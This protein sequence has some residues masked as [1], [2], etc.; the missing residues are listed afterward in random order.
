[1]MQNAGLR[2][3]VGHTRVYAPDMGTLYT[4]EMGT[5]RSTLLALRMRYSDR[6]TTCW[7][8]NMSRLPQLHFT[9]VILHLQE[10][11]QRTTLT[12]P[13]F[14]GKRTDYARVSVKHPV[15]APQQGCSAIII[16]SS[17]SSL[18]HFYVGSMWDDSRLPC[19]SVVHLLS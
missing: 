5:R 7:H 13:F 16:S 1:M 17:S 19:S 3:A 15:H 10:N 9:D 14:N 18:S 8:Q 12:T 2:W 6:A 11:N 4:P